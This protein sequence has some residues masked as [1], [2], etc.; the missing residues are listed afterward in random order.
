LSYVGKLGLSGDGIAGLSLRI[1]RLQIPHWPALGPRSPCVSCRA[2][3]STEERLAAADAH[4]LSHWLALRDTLTAL[5][6]EARVERYE[7][8]LLDAAGHLRT[9]RAIDKS[10]RSLRHIAHARRTFDVV[11]YEGILKTAD[12]LRRSA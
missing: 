2:A 3:S 7:G 12:R 6:A 11:L 1:S 10:M 4:N 9:V 8:R 5:S